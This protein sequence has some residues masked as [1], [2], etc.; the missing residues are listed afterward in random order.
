[1]VV[2]CSLLHLVAETALKFNQLN[3]PQGSMQSPM[4]QPCENVLQPPQIQ[5]KDA[6]S[7]SH[8]L[9]QSVSNCGRVI[10]LSWQSIG[11]IYLRQSFEERPLSLFET[12]N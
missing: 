3:A 1:M 8:W 11:A 6:L 5:R 7:Y 10:S 2:V 12:G 4:W 9:A